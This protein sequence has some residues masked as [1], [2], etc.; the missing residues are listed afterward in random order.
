[1]KP[2]LELIVRI[3]IGGRAWYRVDE[4]NSHDGEEE[5][6]KAEVTLTS[7]DY[8]YKIVHGAKSVLY[9]SLDGLQFWAD[10]GSCSSSAYIMIFLL[11]Q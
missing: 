4:H 1:M 7:Y 11:S 9:I 2:Y 6:V 8:F 5:E 10:P 3:K